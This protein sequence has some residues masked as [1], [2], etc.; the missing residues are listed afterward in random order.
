MKPLSNVNFRSQL[1]AAT[2]LLVLQG[3]VPAAAIGQEMEEIV[4]E[5]R[6][7]SSAEQLINERMSEEVVTDLLGAEMIA[8]VG[9]T[10]VASALRRVSGLSLVGNKFIYVRG[11]G[12]R[13]A[14]TTLNGATIPSPDLSR[15]VIPLDIFPTSI[16]ESLAVQ[17][18]YSS[19]KSAAFGGGNVDIR[20]KSIPTEFTY[21]FQVGSATNS[22]S[23]GD[24]LTYAGGGDDNLGKDDGSRALSG[25]LLS[26]IQRF[27]GDL[28]PQ[29]ILAG[30]KREGQSDAVLAD[31]TAV[32]RQ[33]ALALN[34]DISVVDK[35]SRPDLDVKGSIGNNFFLSD[36]W[37][38]GVMGSAGYNS[39]WRQTRAVARDFVFPT[40]R[41]ETEQE[42]TYAVN[43]NGTF[44]MGVRYTDDH[45]IKTTTLYLL[46]TEDETATIDYFD[47]NREKSGGLGFREQLQRFEER[48]LTVNQISGEHYL[49]G[50]TQ[51]RLSRL[52][53]DK[54]FNI[55]GDEFQF[56]WMYSQARA[57]TDIP[58]EVF[59]SSSTVTDPETGEVLVPNVDID[60]AAV[61]YFFTQ[62]DD[63]VTSARWE[64]IWPIMTARSTIELS[65]GGEHSQKAR[66]YR[67]TQLSLGVLGVADPKILEGP[68]TDVFS[69]ENITDP[70]NQF[71]LDLAGT[72][73]QSYLAATM[74][75][76]L[77][78]KVDWKLDD[79]WRVSAGARWE[80]YRQ[81]A[82]DWNIYAF[83]AS[84]PQISNDPDALARGTYQNDRIYPSVSLT[85]MTEWW[86]EVFQLRFGWS[87][88]V[89]RPDL[90]EI[91][92]A[93]YIDART[94]FLTD[95]NPD[96]RPADFINV[97]MRA[98]WIFN[99]SD[100]VTV[101][102]YRKDIDN[103]IEFFESAASDTNRAREIINA[104]SGSITGLEF[105]SLKSLG[106]LG[107]AFDPFFVQGN[108]TLQETELVAGV[109]ADAPTNN[110]RELSGA[111]GYVGN[112][113][114]GFDSM[115]GSH[116]ATLVYNVF[117]ERLYLA[118]RNGE[119]D[120]Y[121]QPFHSVDMTYS[122][123]PTDLI[124]VRAKLQ[125]LL[126]ETVTIER[127]GV[128]VFEEKPGMT[129]A[130]S[131]N[132]TF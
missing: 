105:E 69:N 113:M 82:L 114:L 124:T 3:L 52:V 37:E 130:L 11:L 45:L 7:R 131:I 97:D 99:N 20:T 30:L 128:I 14:S 22:E 88:T 16:V 56:N 87:E 46:N 2:S 115:G 48:T 41:F 36:D 121:E 125:N 18:S 132:L 54:V 73:N 83:S 84:S 117:G 123:Y 55:L 101:T 63:D 4:V 1:A 108:I 68:L 126:N 9:D 116:A 43:M 21:S 34:R 119:P 122:W 94:G 120:G 70:A 31:A 95:G 32:N 118:G 81:V 60:S 104:E 15:N 62:L 110:V 50:A 71:I 79:K 127:E 8:R 74:T 64:V 129:A 44:N 5:G 39:G 42:S 98:E 67:Q 57:N 66:T 80:D 24:M 109:Q 59:V 13:Y 29:T 78:G 51:D 35:G 25:V 53:P 93:S 27:N 91:T 89:V 96:V 6:L 85:Y 40:E 76:A 112:F 23:R 106:F 33:L 111:S 65:A 61:D 107:Q 90:R 10:D 86:A 103:P 92:D 38:I 102:L 58:S 77:F 28:D 47:E 100:T 75:D 17:K 19:D 26:S 49:G 72:N 12:E